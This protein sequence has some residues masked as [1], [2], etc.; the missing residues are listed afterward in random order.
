[1]AVSIEHGVIGLKFR[2]GAFVTFCFKNFIDEIMT[3]LTERK[4]IPKEKILIFLDNASIHLSFFMQYYFAKK[5]Y[6]VILML[7]IPLL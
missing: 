1:M 5:K 2:K 3:E 6:N 4:N 7:H